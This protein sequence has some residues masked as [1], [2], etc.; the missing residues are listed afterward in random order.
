MTPATVTDFPSLDRIL[1]EAGNRIRQPRRKNVEPLNDLR[2]VRDAIRRV[3]KLTAGLRDEGVY[4]VCDVT[5]R[6]DRQELVSC[7][8]AACAM[9]PADVDPGAALSWCDLPAREWPGWLVER[10][11][12]R[13]DAG[14]V[15]ATAWAGGRERDRRRNPAVVAS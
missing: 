13:R 11:A 5:D 9:L 3:V 1:T 12:A 10:E 14:A 7:L 6:L 15:D 8:V 4:N 2:A